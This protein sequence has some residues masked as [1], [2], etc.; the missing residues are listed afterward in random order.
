MRL[1]VCIC[2]FGLLLPVGRLMPSAD[3]YDS[4]TNKEVYSETVGTYKHSGNHGSISLWLALDS[5][6]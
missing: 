5:V 1:L 4:D 2:I 3:I 6:I